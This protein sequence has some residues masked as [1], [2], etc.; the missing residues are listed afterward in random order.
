[1]FVSRGEILRFFT[2]VG[3][4]DFQAGAFLR[5]LARAKSVATLHLVDDGNSTAYLQVPRHILSGEQRISSFLRQILSANGNDA[6]PVP[7]THFFWGAAPVRP[8]VP[9]QRRLASGRGFGSQ[10]TMSQKLV[11]ALARW[12][13][14]SLSQH[15]VSGQLWQRSLSGTHRTVSES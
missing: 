7:Q 11:Q 6:V 5:S 9:V 8:V 10:P 12:G 1:M 14:R 2:W 15:N 4:L 3:D 13:V